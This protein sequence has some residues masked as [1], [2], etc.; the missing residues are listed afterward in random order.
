MHFCL[1]Q[2]LPGFYQ[3]CALGHSDGP[4]R[5]EMW[6]IHGS[7]LGAGDLPVPLVLLLGVSPDAA[8]L[9]RG[10]IRVMASAVEIYLQNKRMVSTIPV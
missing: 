5:S 2:S 8:P 6:G 4:R 3:V 1:K 9:G 10:D 7:V